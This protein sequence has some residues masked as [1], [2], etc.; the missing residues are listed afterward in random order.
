M[1]AKIKTLTKKEYVRFF[2][3]IHLALQEA[4]SRGEKEFKRSSLIYRACQF[5]A[6]FGATPGKIGFVIDTPISS[7]LQHGD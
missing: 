3:C 5:G 2:G 6:A 1:P 4:E 7:F